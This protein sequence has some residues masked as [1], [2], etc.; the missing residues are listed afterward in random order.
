[1]SSRAPEARDRWRI[2]VVGDELVAG[3]GDARGMG[4]TGRVAART[5]SEDPIELFCLP[6]PDETSTALSGRW[7]SECNR[8]FGNG[9]NRLVVAPGSAD[10][11]QG[12]SLARSRLN[13]ANVLDDASNRNIRA[14]VMGPPPRNDV[15]PRQLAELSTA[16][17]DVCARRRVPYVETY[18]PLQDHEQ[19][20]ADLASTGGRHPEQAGYGLLAWLVLHNGWH[21]WLGL[22]QDG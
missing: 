5:R 7:E 12:V 18:Q 6:V 21:E 3:I 1:M 8:R 10:L 14:F 11:R 19:W 15:D 17:A 2:C 20:L 13:L 9:E 22:P 16:F 4:W